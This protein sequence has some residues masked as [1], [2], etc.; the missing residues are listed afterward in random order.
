MGGISSGT[1]VVGDV[2]GANNQLQL[3]GHAYAQEGIT[4]QAKQSS[5]APSHILH[6]G[7]TT[8]GLG[9]I[10]L[11]AG[12]TTTHYMIESA[13]G[14]L[15]LSGNIIGGSGTPAVVNLHLRGAGNGSISGNID[16]ANALDLSLTKAGAGT[17]TLTGGNAY[18]GPTTVSA[19]KLAIGT[20]ANPAGTINNSAVTIN[21]PT[22]NFAYNSISNYINT[23]TFTQGTLSGTN[24]NGSLAG[25]TIDANKTIAPGNSPGTANT[26]TQIWAGGGTYQWEIN[27]AN[28]TAGGTSGWDLLN[29]TGA[30]TQTATNGNKFTIDITG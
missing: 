29:L 5:A 16:G 3:T 21:G 30:L 12:G 13:A 20:A 15:N 19:G 11:A 23:L 1:T 6:T 26:A 28:G 17:W 10:T 7:G 18:D 8:T 24:W 25:L 14:S 22:A 9:N 4:L 27:N 2:A